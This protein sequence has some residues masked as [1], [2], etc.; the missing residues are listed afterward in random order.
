M[1]L[2]S[3]A[4]VEEALL[5]MKEGAS[6]QIGGSRCHSTY[7]FYQGQWRREDF[8]ESATYESVVAESVILNLA[9]SEP[10]AFR[11]L[12]RVARWNRFV[13]AFFAGELHAARALLPEACRYGDPNLEGETWAALLDWPATAL[14]PQMVERLRRKVSG[15]T[16]YHLFMVA[17]GWKEG[18]RNSSARAA[19]R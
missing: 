1:T 13:E 16:A 19:I 10:A 18:P 8:D 2:L 5:R 14:Q 6:V 3:A 15:M 9:E 11:D 17:M 4:E 12:L 7:S